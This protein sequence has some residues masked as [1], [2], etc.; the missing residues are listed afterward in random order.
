[1]SKGP[2]I[3]R[4]CNW[5]GEAVLSL[6]TLTMLAHEGYELHLIGKRWAIS[7]FEGHGFAVHVRPAKRADAIKQLKALRQQLSQAHPGFSSRPNM[8]LFTNSFSSALEARLAGLKPIGYR[9]EG[10]GLLLAHGVPYT[11][12]LHAADNYW[13]VG[14]HFA[15][16]QAARPTQL[17]LQPSAQH[18]AQAN[19]LLQVNDIAG[20]FAVLCPFSGVADTTG[21][22]HWPPFAQLAHSLQSQGLTVV[23][24]PGPGEEAQA[25]NDYPGAKVLTG[26]DLGTYAALAQQARCTVSNDTGPGHLAAAAGGRLISVLGPDAASMWWPEGEH[27]TVLRPASGWPTLADALA[28]VNKASK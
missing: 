15:G 5:V 1:M 2:L 28:A 21:K 22:K 9:T 4:L 26:V 11:P 24:C 8:L 16:V 13:R 17:G 3:V 7:L 6:P 10:R 27:V 25:R 19:A 14:T 18:T 23:L 20:D 12:G